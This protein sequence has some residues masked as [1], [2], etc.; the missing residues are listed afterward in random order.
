MYALEYLLNLVNPGLEFSHT[1]SLL[2]EEQRQSKSL[3]LSMRSPQHRLPNLHTFIV[4]I[5][6]KISLLPPTALQVKMIGSNLSTEYSEKN[7]SLITFNHELI[8]GICY[9]NSHYLDVTNDKIKARIYSGS[10]FKIPQV[11][12]RSKHKSPLHSLPTGNFFNEITIKN[13]KVRCHKWVSETIFKRVRFAKISEIK[14][15]KQNETNLF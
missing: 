3:C 14:V 9:W 8:L 2:K 10:K 13:L 4:G 6:N 12:G 7:I 11:P 1:C 15:I 5:H